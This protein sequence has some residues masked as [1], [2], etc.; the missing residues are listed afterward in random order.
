MDR[1]D[2]S[3]REAIVGRTFRVLEAVLWAAAA[4]LFAG[5]PVLNWS[6]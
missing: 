6:D 5:G 1:T 4:L 2:R 3:T